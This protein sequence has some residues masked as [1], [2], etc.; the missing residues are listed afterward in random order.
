VSE[1]SLT[2]PRSSE[3]Y[4]RGGT[5]KPD[6]TGRKARQGRAESPIWPLTWGDIRLSRSVPANARAAEIPCELSSQSQ[7]GPWPRAFRK[8]LLG[9]WGEMSL[10]FI[11]VP[12]MGR[13]AAG[14]PSTPAYVVWGLD[15]TCYGGRN[16]GVK[17]G[18]SPIPRRQDVERHA[19]GSCSLYQGP[20][21]SAAAQT[22]LFLCARRVGRPG[23]RCDSAINELNIKPLL[24]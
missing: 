21:Q 17:P 11:L 12:A 18:R 22:Q 13:G 7:R 14:W 24:Q 20:N 9:D 5:P 15:G 8:L 19:R 4:R 2:S 16:K 6:E 10:F 1:R 3:H 23:L